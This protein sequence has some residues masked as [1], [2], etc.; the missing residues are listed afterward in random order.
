MR[1][2][3]GCELQKEDVGSVPALLVDFDVD[4]ARRVVDFD[5]VQW[6]PPRCSSCKVFG[7]VLNECPKKI[8]PDVVKN[9]NNPRHA[10]RGVPV[11]PKDDLGTNKGNSKSAEKRSLNVAHDSSSNTSIIDNINKLERHLLNGK[12]RFVNDDGN[13]LVPTGNVDSDS[14]VEVVFDETVNLMAST[15]FKGRSN[16]VYSTNSLLEQWRETKQE[17]DYD[18]YDDDLYESHYMSDHLQA[19]CDDLD[20]TFFDRK[21]K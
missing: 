5:V 1:G 20:I 9:L 11:G 13:P 18:P 14:E 15:S 3:S 19:I 6:K 16:R 4:E 17:D 12:L 8:I 10:T 2:L 21:K 7:H